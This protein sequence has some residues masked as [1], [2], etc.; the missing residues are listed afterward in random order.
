MFRVQGVFPTYRP[1]GVQVHG[2]LLPTA[3]A[4][5]VPGLLEPAEVGAP[6]TDMSL[7]RH[8][9]RLDSEDNPVTRSPREYRRLQGFGESRNYQGRNP[10]THAA[11]SS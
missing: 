5:L 7:S 4:Y 2:S 10:K 8:P 9:R 11:W 1:P 3:L 6:A